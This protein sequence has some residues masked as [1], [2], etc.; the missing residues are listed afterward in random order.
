MTGKAYWEE[1]EAACHVIPMARKEQ[2]TNAV[3]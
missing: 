2:E 3:T 1:H